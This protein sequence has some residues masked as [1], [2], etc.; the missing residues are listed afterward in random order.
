[1][2][3]RAAAPQVD[4]KTTRPIAIAPGSEPGEWWYRNRYGNYVKLCF[5]ND[6]HIANLYQRLIAEGRLGKCFEVIKA[7]ALKRGIIGS[8]GTVAE[9]FIRTA[10]KDGDPAGD[11]DFVHED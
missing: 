6:Y 11:E 4:D 2:P 1:M 9:R 3:K 10:K 8:D 5:V 7:E